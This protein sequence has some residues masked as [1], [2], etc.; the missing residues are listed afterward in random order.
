MR[1][2][3]RGA[4]RSSPVLALISF[5]I[6]AAQPAMAQEGD[7]ATT[8]EPIVCADCHDD[9]HPEQL[10]KTV[11]AGLSCTDCHSGAIDLAHTEG[12]LEL[13]KVDCATCHSDAVDAL[14][15]S[16]H[17]R[18]VFTGISGKPACQTCHGPVHE[19][20]PH[21]DP[22]SRVG[23]AR[24]AMTCAQCHASPEIARRTGVHLIQPLAAY[25]ASVHAKAIREG[26][27]AAD[28]ASCHG[29]HGILP[30]SDAASKVNH[31]QVPAT[32]GECHA[33]IAKAF[34]GSVHGQA[35]TRGVREAP[36]CTDCHGEH[37]ILAPSDPGSPVS[38]TNL[39]RMTCGR[40]H[41][42]VRVS[43]KYGMP[44]DVVASFDDSY[45][46]L[47][48]KAGNQ[49]VANC[50]S[51]HGVHNILPSSDPRSMVSKVNLS[52]T[53]G[54]CHPG[55]G[56]R[57]AIGPVHVVS[58][59]EA[60]SPAVYWVRLIY[61]WLIW[62]VIGG[63]VLHNALDLRRKVMSPIR[64]PI[65]PVTERRPRMRFG[66]RLVHGLTMMSFITL[67]YTGFALKYPAAWWARP[68]LAWE[69]TIALRGS[70]HRGAA[71]VMVAAFLG[72]FVH[73]AVS[74]EARACVRKMWPTRRDL[75]ELR[76]R[77][78][79][80]FGRRAEMPKSPTLGYVEKAEYLAL[81]WGTAVMAFTG[82]LLWFENFTLRWMPK[83]VIDISTVVHFY[84]AVLATL[85]ILVWHFY[86]VIF[87]PLV[88]PMDTAWL[89]GREVPGRSLEREPD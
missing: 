58:T 66:F 23:P 43:Q 89:T 62:L 36:V 70:I 41:G 14:Q 39:P 60:S 28:C 88:Y 20:M 72:H 16:I 15:K 50:A 1:S 45:H 18:P 27:P 82:F 75:H 37:R 47:A 21:D 31:Q 24:V 68:L 10:E 4:L 6:W 63:M 80:Y 76:E 61:L 46:G 53:C 54:H 81:M 2:I 33:D 59:D 87:D 85:A 55:A 49:T 79:W 83:W 71:L 38:A 34:A 35:A 67:A 3:I 86:F 22:A 48:G 11:H 74:K 7:D 42:D 56:T 73:L 77:L 29:S 65:V 40:C 9:V 57:F 19:I 52:K 25:N 51:C 78:A 12:N 5:L 26:R 32:C 30:A 17:G 8:N 84:E 44:S 64:P 13:T 69:E